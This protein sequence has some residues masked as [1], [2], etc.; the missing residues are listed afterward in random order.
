MKKFFITFIGIF[1]TCIILSFSIIKLINTEA[2]LYQ[3]IS[4]N[5]VQKMIENNE[6]FILYMYQ[7]NCSSCQQVTPIINDYIKEN[8]KVFAVDINSDDNK[9]YILQDLNIKGTP[10]VIFYNKGEESGRFTSIFSKDE[11]YKKIELN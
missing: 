10:T 7:K 6:S 1:A 8:N 5:E 2:A 11:F 4:T 3:N 9:N